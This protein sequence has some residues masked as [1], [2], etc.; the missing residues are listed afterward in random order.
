MPAQQSGKHQLRVFH[1]ISE[2][3][4][5]VLVTAFEVRR[6]IKSRQSRKEEGVRVTVCELVPR[7]IKSRVIKPIGCF[8]GISYW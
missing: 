3:N 4:A 8:A 6:A 2:I 5:H 1:V 7:N